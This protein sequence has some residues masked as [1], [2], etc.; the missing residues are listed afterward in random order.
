MNIQ[1][2]IDLSLLIG[3]NNRCIGIDLI[4]IIQ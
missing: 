4:K 2:V 1:I 3:K